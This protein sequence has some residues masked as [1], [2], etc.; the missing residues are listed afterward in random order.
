MHMGP[1]GDDAA[2]VG[3]AAGV[4]VGVAAAAGVVL[5]AGFRAAAVSAA[6]VAVAA[7]VAAA[8]G[9]F[10]GQVVD[11]LVAMSGAAPR[12]Y[13]GVES[14]QGCLSGTHHPVGPAD[15]TGVVGLGESGVA[16]S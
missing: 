9:V 11:D 1:L 16:P 3:A 4:G 13:P 14:L 2:G 15:A 12:S 8:V 7:R 5:G 6:G 10:C